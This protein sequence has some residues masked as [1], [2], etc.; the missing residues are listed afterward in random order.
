MHLIKH[1]KY[2]KQ[3]TRQEWRAVDF[4]QLKSFCCPFSTVISVQKWIT[5]PDNPYC[6]SLPGKFWA[7]VLLQVLLVRVQD[8]REMICRADMWKQ[9]FSLSLFQADVSVNFSYC[10]FAFHCSWSFSKRITCF[11]IT[12]WGIICHH[13]W[14]YLVYIS[15]SL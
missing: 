14:E 11:P 15:L 8:S 12:H 6:S 2:E 1:G 9:L 3:L 4:I 5:Y 7:A 10:S 13:H